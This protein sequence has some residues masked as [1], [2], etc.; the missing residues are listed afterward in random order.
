MI[1]TYE[2]HEAMNNTLP[3]SA[4]SCDV[5]FPKIHFVLFHFQFIAVVSTF[6]RFGIFSLL[7]S[8]LA[9]LYAELANFAAYN[10]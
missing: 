7:V 4:G 3:I 1:S 6:D 10:Q 9:F 8:K 2:I 5:A